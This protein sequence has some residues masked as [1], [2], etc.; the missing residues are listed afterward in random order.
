M[1][2][3]ILAGLAA[4][5]I[6]CPTL[7]ATQPAANADSGGAAN[8]PAPAAKP[9]A[10]PNQRL[11]TPT[12]EGRQ[13]LIAGVAE[14][15]LR[16]FNLVR[17]KIPPVLLAAMADAYERPF[18]S[19]CTAL[20]AQVRILDDVVGPDLDEPVSTTNP[21]LM[22]RGEVATRNATLDAL[23][24]ATTDSIPFHSWVR[25]L[26]GAQRHDQLVLSAITAGAVRRAYLKGLGEAR[27]CLPPGVPRHLAH[28]SRVAAEARPS[29]VSNP[30][31]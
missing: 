9:A 5:L 27:G 11:L 20:A 16:D 8:P 30:S 10:D 18:P 2:G 14:Q 23:R 17:S 22:S 29:Q 7:A 25:L 19:D 26:T 4:T 21:S 13:N 24:E 3:A 28:P 31:N 6:L 15:P 12:E 1:R